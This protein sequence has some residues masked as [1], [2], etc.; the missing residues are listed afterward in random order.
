M[1]MAHRTNE[2]LHI[3]NSMDVLTGINWKYNWRIYW[4]YNW[5]FMKIIEE[6]DKIINLEV[7]LKHIYRVATQTTE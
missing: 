4:E 6:M 1:K 5:N 3:N 2:C 7:N